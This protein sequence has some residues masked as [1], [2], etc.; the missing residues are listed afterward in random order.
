[1]AGQ[2]R[3]LD[4]QPMPL[5]KMTRIRRKHSAQFG[6]QAT[7]ELVQDED[8]FKTYLKHPQRKKF[9]ERHAKHYE[10]VLAFDFIQKTK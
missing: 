1:L 8:A 2:G 10:R 6:V 4:S 5:R 9:I 3:Q 7:G